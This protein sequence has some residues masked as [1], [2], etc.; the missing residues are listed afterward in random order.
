MWTFTTTGFYSAVQHR[1]NPDLLM[2]RARDEESLAPLVEATG[3]EIVSTPQADYAFR[4]TVTKRQYADWLAAAVMGIDYPNF[5]NRAHTARGG[6]FA[7]VLHEVWDVM[8]RFQ[9]DMKQRSK[10]GN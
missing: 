3:A 4:V 10:A 6:L 5:K 9:K 1:D 2:V 8:Y 7:G